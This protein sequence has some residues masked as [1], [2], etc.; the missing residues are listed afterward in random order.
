MSQSTTDIIDRLAAIAPGSR[1]D[2]I[3]SERPEARANAQAS[4]R[5]LFAPSEPGTLGV[6]QRFALAA[7]VAGLHGDASVTD[8]YREGL[9][10]AGGSAELVDAV[11]RE[12]ARGA[13]QGPYGAYPA[14]P[15]SAENA[16]GLAYHVLDTH[17]A[18]LGT[19]LAAS[20]EH[21]HLLVF[22]PRDA[23]R[24]ALEAARAAGLSETDIVTLSQLVSFLA[25]QIRSIAGLS[26]LAAA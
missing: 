21:A 20:F 2:A 6:Q 4:Y 10:G 26:V 14:G 8:F 5:A 1:L 18:V 22:H 19:E 24:A 12:T 11:A 15:L 13:T 3:R 25:F 17:R 7:F 16:E 23:S 9:A